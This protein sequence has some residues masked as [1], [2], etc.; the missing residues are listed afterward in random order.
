M[1]AILLSLG[2]NL[3]AWGTVQAQ[4][5]GSGATLPA[6][7]YARWAESYAKKQGTPVSY[8]ASGSGEG[9]RLVSERLVQFGASDVPLSAEELARRQLIQVPMLVGGIV[10]VVQL[11]GVGSNRLQLSGEVLAAIMSGE[12]SRWN[13][14]RIAE[15]NPGLALPS[16]RIKRVVRADKSGTSDSF[17]RYLAGQSPRFAQTVG[18]GMQP[19]WGGELITAE[20][21]DGVANAVRGNEGAI[22]YVSHDSVSRDKL[23]AVQLKNADGQWVNAS[24]LSFRSAIR[25]SDLHTKGDDHA[26]LLNR[27]GADS[28]PITVTSFA[29]FDARP[30]SADQAAPT[31]RFL[32]WCFVQGDEQLRGTGFAP[33]PASVQSRMAARF[34]TVKP[35]DGSAPHYQSL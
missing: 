29:L 1:G 12:I 25:H 14:A 23:A 8:K 20:G 7:V 5:V 27:P 30:A 4:V 32:Y 10:P 15:L 2:V 21:N 24:E 31:L 11:P 22:G 16:T 33:L 6:K 28:W 18:T 26:S 19:K 17:S 34:D 13:D 3:G 35:K 9:L